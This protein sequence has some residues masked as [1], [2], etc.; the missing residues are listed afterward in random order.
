MPPETPTPTPEEITKI[1]RRYIPE[2]VRCSADCT[3]YLGNE[4]EGQNRS[5]ITSSYQIGKCD[6]QGLTSRRSRHNETVTVG[7]PCRHLPFRNIAMK[8][9]YFPEPTE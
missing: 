2:V 5:G 1:G 9:E 8:K 4:G 7:Q 6:Y 3:L